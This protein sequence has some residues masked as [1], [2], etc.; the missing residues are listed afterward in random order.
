MIYEVVDFEVIDVDGEVGTAGGVVMDVKAKA[1]I[2]SVKE[3]FRY[4]NIYLCPR[5]GD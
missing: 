1:H 2:L 4:R 3:S 5:A